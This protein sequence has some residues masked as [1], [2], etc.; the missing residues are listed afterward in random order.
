MWVLDHKESWVLKNWCFWTVVLEKTLESPLDC[1]EIKPVNPKGNQ[2]WIITGR[3]DAETEAP[4]LWPPDAK[5]CLIIKDPDAGKD[6]S[7]EK[8]GTTGDEMV[9]WH[10]Q[11][12]GHEFEQAPGVGD[13]QARCSPWGHKKPDVTERLNWSEVIGSCLQQLL[14][15]PGG[16]DG[17]ESA[18][19]EGDLGLFP[20]LGRSPGGGHGNPLQYSCLENSHGQRSL[21]GYSLWGLKESDTTKHSQKKLLLCRANMTFNFPHSFISQRRIGILL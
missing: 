5:K 16:S 18:C 9:G 12:N 20:G 2:S 4:I 6:W 1:K 13:G 21:V 14:G 15:F 7:Q 11:L 10:H 17:K 3:T 8:K 19:S